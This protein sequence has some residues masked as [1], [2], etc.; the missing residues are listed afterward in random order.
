VAGGVLLLAGE[1]GIGKSTLVLQLLAGVTA[2]GRRPLLVTGEESPEQVALRARRLD[3]GAE[4]VRAVGT[5]VLEEALAAATAENADVLVVDSIQTLSS[6][7]AGAPGGSV[8]QVRDCA[9]A[10]IRHAKT[11][12]AVVVVVGHVTKDGAVA[13]PK[14]LEHLVDVVLSLD[15]ERS[16]TLRLLRAM[17]NR[18]GPCDET[19][20]F[21]MSGTGLVPVPDPSSF[22]L[23]DRTHGVPGSIV[24][25]SLEGTRPV[26]VELQALVTRSAAPQP[27]RVVIGLDPARIAMLL[28]V[29]DGR[30][31][32][33]FVDRDVFAA[34]AGGFAVREP[35]ADL[36]LA[37]ALHSARSGRPL[38]SDVVAVGEVGLGGEVRRVPGVERRLAEA[39]R[40][41]VRHA[42]VPRGTDAVHASLRVEVVENLRAA[43]D[44]LSG[45][46]R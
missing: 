32:V 21:T 33:T 28:G 6:A 30:A 3:A 38:A 4:G 15:G 46:P 12:G 25:P 17:K 2:A 36:A 24:F 19:G 13:G 31:G 42:L 9:A 18:F 5:T 10:L 35:A 14:T 1:P 40:L 43:V 22:L 8:V 37:L 26:L 27:R 16:G 23:A 29:L 20:V 7:A 41:G 34:A 39:A 45:A 11:T 44:V